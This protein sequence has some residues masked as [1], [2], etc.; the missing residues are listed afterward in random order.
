MVY[1]VI[2]TSTAEGVTVD[3][4]A[5]TGAA[6]L[7]I[8]DDIRAQLA[9]PAS[10]LNTG[11]ITAK[12]MNGATLQIA[13]STSAGP[14]QCGEAAWCAPNCC[15]TLD[16]GGTGLGTFNI[17]VDNSFTAYV[18]GNELGSTGEWAT[19]TYH[20]DAPC[21]DGNVYAIH[22]VD[23]GGPSAI[24]ASI[25]DGCGATT[26][27]GP[28]WKCTSDDPGAGWHDQGFDD[29]AWTVAISGGINGASPWGVRPGISMQSHWVWAHDLL[30]T[31]EVWC[32][33]TSGSHDYDDGMYANIE[34]HDNGQIHVGADDSASKC[35]SNPHH[36]LISRDNLN[37]LLVLAVLYVNGN[38]IGETTVA[39]WDQTER[40]SVRFFKYENDDSSIE[41]DDS[42]LENDDSSLKS[43]HL[44]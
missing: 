9:D 17:F 8:Q 14:P 7:A 26:I 31:D 37:M 11:T 39:Q 35:A 41:Y 16:G 27:T 12:I 15:A 1:R 40:F 43:H 10:D 18:N 24:I 13:T 23:T 2:Q 22:G 30:G 44:L 38:R 33:I 29:T 20:F 3:I 19:H 36:D 34:G 6:A 32:R 25:D 42:S 21:G 4:F 5:N 28:N